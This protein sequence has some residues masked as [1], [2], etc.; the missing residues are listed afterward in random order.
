MFAKIYDTPDGVR[1]FSELFL[2]ATKNIV[3]YDYHGRWTSGGEF[4]LVFPADELLV[5]TIREEKVIE[6]DGDWLF[7]EKTFIDQESLT[8]SG[9]DAKGLLNLRKALWGETQEEGA[10]GYDIVSGTT[11]ECVLH[12]LTN[13]MIDPELSQRKMPLSFSNDSVRGLADDHYR[14]RLQYV[15]D[16]VQE[17][18]DGAGIGFTVAGNYS[19]G[20]FL[21]SLRSG[22]DRSI[23]QN[24]RARVIFT[25]AWGNVEKQTHE[26]DISNYYN[27]VYATG[28][29]VTIPVYRTAAVPSGLHRRE[30]SVDVNVSSENDIR[31]Y[32]LE[33]VK[34]N[35]K[36]EQYTVT[37]I[38]S[39]WG[40]DF[41]LGDKVTVRNR[42][43]HDS[44]SGVITEVQKNYS[45][46]RKEIQLTIGDRK[47]KFIGQIVNNLISGTQ[48]RR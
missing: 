37:P 25:P 9:I 12:Y 13:N 31:D 40:K 30:T 45:S 23:E 46:G 41:D 8:I 33:A 32:A 28:A 27:A 48:K 34:D 26:E 19:S 5:T 4:T 29:G 18:C 42:F 6:L 24:S 1:D 22:V 10:E 3:S 39:G 36:R 15:G 47:I 38:I 14:A 11:R 35:I 20:K 43:N 44:Y 21:F 2:M 7:V 16:I 17:L